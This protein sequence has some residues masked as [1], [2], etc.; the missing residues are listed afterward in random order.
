MTTITI[1][2]TGKR[3]SIGTIILLSLFV[4]GI[5]ASIFRWVDGFSGMANIS[6]T[7][8]WGIWISFDL[9]VGVAISAG[10]F[11]LAATVHIFHIKTFQP[12]LRP[13]LLTGFLGYVLVI[14]SLLVDLGQPQRI[15]QML[16]YRNLHSP[17]FEVGMCVMTYT[18]VLFLEFSPPVFE[19]LDWTGVL[20]VIKKISIP[21]VILGVVLSTM[22]QSSLGSLFLIVPY[23]MYPLWYSSLLPLIFLVSAIAAGFGMVIFECSMSHRVFGGQPRRDVFQGLA[24]GLL[25]TLLLLLLIK[26]IDLTISGEWSLIIENSLQSNMFILE[27]LIGVILPIAIL[28]VPT[29]RKNIAWIFRAGLM[30]VMGLILDR[31]NIGLIGMAGA[32]YTPHWM[33]LAVTVGL[34]AGG[35]LVFGLAMKNLPLEVHE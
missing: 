29:F 34:F 11:I 9:L 4:L 26:S 8:P 6:D 30:T 23:K 24:K 22:H 25:V 28:I 27:N 14:L 15:W 16:I 7:R 19:K 12:I 17:L 3:F 33:E 1:P 2:F 32:S 21:I 5:A 18:F 31:L 10:A 35:I 13:A 20:K